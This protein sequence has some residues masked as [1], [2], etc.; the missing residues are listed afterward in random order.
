MDNKLEMRESTS[1]Y[2]PAYL[3]E[4]EDKLLV[5]VHI[6]SFLS[7]AQA[8]NVATMIHLQLENYFKTHKL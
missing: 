6:D 3:I 2:N 8:H 1:V 4:S 5:T 7:E